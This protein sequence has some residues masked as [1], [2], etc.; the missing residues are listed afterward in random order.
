MLVFSLHM[1]HA[2]HAANQVLLALLVFSCLNV[3]RVV[4]VEATC[5]LLWRQLF[6]GQFEYAANCDEWGNTKVTALELYP[7]IQRAVRSHVAM[8]WAYI[9]LAFALNVPWLLA[10]SYVGEHLDLDQLRPMEVA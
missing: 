9:A 4:F 7:A 5:R 3:S 8:G 2:L 1:L 6:T 10:L